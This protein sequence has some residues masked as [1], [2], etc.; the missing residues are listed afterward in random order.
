MSDVFDAPEEALAPGSG[1]QS[2]LDDSPEPVQGQPRV[3]LT[4]PDNGAT[5]G[6]SSAVTLNAVASH[7]KRRVRRVEFFQG[8][9]L[10]ATDTTSPYNFTWENVPAGNH[11]LT[12]RVIND[13]GVAA[14]SPSVDIVVLATTTHHVSTSGNDST[15]D[16]S[17]SNPWRTLKY[18]ATRATWGDTLALSAGVF[19]ELGPI[20]IPP[21]VNVIGMGK[22]QTIIKAHSSFYY[23][24]PSP[25]YAFD[26]YL[27]RLVSNPVV[28]GS[29]RLMGFKVD[30]DGRKL[31]GGIYVNRRNHVTLEQVE[32]TGTHFNA[33]WVLN[34]TDMIVRDVRLINT[35]WASTDWVAGALHVINLERTLIERIHIDEDIGYG[36]KTIGAGGPGVKMHDIVIRDSWISVSPD[37]IWNGGLANISIEFWN[38]DIAR[39]EVTNSYVDNFISVVSDDPDAVPTGVPVIRIHH[40]VIDLKTRANGVG[41]GVEV[42]VNDVEIDHNYFIW[43]AYGIVDWGQ[44]RRSNWFIHHNVFYNLSGYWPGDIV[45]TQ[46][47][48]LRNLRF[49]NNTIEFDNDR[50]L[51]VIGMHGGDSENLD[52]A[53]NIVIDLRPGEYNH[54]PKVFMRLETGNGATVS[55]LSVRNNLLFNLPMGSVPGSYQANLSANPMLVAA[56][57]RPEPYYH[58]TAASPAINTGVNVGFPYSG[59]APDMGAYE[60][61]STPPTVSLT[62]PADGATFSAP[63]TITLTANASDADGSVSKVEFFQGSTLL[64]TDTTSPYSFT[65]SNVAAGSYTLTARATDSSGATSTSPA[66]NIT[67]ASGG[68]VPTSG[69][70]LWLKGDVGVNLNGSTVSQ[71]LDQSG[72]ARHATQASASSQPTYL[73]ADIHGMPALRFDGLNDFLTFNLP[74]NNLTGMT[75]FLVSAAT[76]DPTGGSVHA[77]SAAIF[78]NETASWGT[79]YLSPFQSR[80]QWRFGTTQY[81][82]WPTYVRPTSIWNAYSLTVSQK[83]GAVDSLYVNGT[84]VQRE[85]G[86]LTMIAGCRDVGNL[87]RGYNDNTYFPGKIAEVLV[88]NRALNDSERAQVEAYLKNKYFTGMHLAPEA[89]F[90]SPASGAAPLTPEQG[91]P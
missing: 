66:V 13:T 82:N 58:L 52:I 68:G 34:G 35:A 70:Q 91:T 51:H 84:L 72:N 39:C 27:I 73:S 71:W 55:Q 26:K 17:P 44:I 10:L 85:S 43:G 75:L 29:Q 54:Y 89:S 25:G 24:P 23:N 87:G 59:P 36:I 60:Y 21:G 77:Q 1:V 86:K 46:N 8:S 18:A 57:A 61:S 65:W 63:A 80:V 64:A 9:T 33:I 2:L 69:L 47:A 42:T 62:S 88:Y 76:G 53:N 67:V 41:M 11:T 49:Y 32:V 30:G 45:R 40:N 48:G 3:R 15:G 37:G 22:D 12:A 7:E 31:H 20:D 74:V 14:T 19:V 90:Y 16:G 50:T 56:G 81:G 28:D 4:Q 38:V 83:D 6:A 79:V 5:F 78:W